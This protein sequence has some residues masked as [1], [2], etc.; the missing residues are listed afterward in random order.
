MVIA[1]RKRKGYNIFI[2]SLLKELSPKVTEEG[3]LR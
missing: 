2:G 3:Y 1:E